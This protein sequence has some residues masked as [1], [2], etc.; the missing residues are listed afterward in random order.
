MVAQDYYALLRV[1]QA[2]RIQNVLRGSEFFRVPCGYE[3]FGEPGGHNSVIL[4]AVSLTPV[5]QGGSI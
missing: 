3:P 1:L 5:W 2:L 4:R